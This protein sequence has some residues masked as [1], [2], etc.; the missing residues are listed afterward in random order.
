MK[1]SPGSAGR[2]IGTLTTASYYSL[3]R[4]KGRP[5]PT[6]RKTGMKGPLGRKRPAHQRGR[7]GKPRGLPYLCGG[8][9]TRNLKGHTS[10]SW[11]MK[12]K[13][14]VTKKFNRILAEKEKKENGSHFPHVGCKEGRKEKKNQRGKKNCGEGHPWGR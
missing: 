5:R 6:W 14:G 2:K 7:K 1:T 10:M 13:G 8:D 4:R 3:E 12:E 11:R 9:H